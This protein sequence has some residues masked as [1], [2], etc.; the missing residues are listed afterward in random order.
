MHPPTSS[1][2]AQAWN[3]S[4]I[5]GFFDSFL[6]KVARL[7]LVAMATLA[8]QLRRCSS[9][10]LAPGRG[11]TSAHLLHTS[12]MHRV[13]HLATRWV[14]SLAMDWPRAMQYTQVCPKL[15]ECSS[16]SLAPGRGRTSAHL[17]H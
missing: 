8:P 17:S 1:P 5:H 10:R 2:H 16:R 14:C 9:R 12:E 11:R 6:S 3:S 7:V 4:R 13:W 15:R